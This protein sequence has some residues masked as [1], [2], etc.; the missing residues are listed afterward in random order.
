MIIL[1]R[2]VHRT[3]ATHGWPVDRSITA[4][5]CCPEYSG[6]ANL[7]VS[8]SQK[9]RSS[10]LPNGFC[11]RCPAAFGEGWQVELPNHHPSD[12]QY[13]IRRSARVFVNAVA[14]T[15]Q[16]FSECPAIPGPH[17]TNPK[18]TSFASSFESAVAPQ[19]RRY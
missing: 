9:W 11:V 5:I 15:F 13:K 1:C 18:V 16:M 19:V 3:A 6:A 7:G 2:V 12:C 14:S 8:C 17:V 4:E 10:L